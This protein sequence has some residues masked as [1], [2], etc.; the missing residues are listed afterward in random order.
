MVARGTTGSAARSGLPVLTCGSIVKNSYKLVVEEARR[1]TGNNKFRWTAA[2]ELLLKEEVSKRVILVDPALTNNSKLKE[3]A[4]DQVTNVINLNF[5]LSLSRLQVRKKFN[6]AKYTGKARVTM[7]VEKG[8]KEDGKLVAR[9]WGEFRKYGRGTGGGEPMLPPSCNDDDDEEETPKTE[10]NFFLMDTP[11]TMKVLE[12]PKALRPS[13]FVLKA[14]NAC[15]P[16]STAVSGDLKI[17]IEEKTVEQQEVDQ[18]EEEE[19]RVVPA[20]VEPERK[21]KRAS[22]VDTTPSHPNAISDQYFTARLGHINAVAPLKLQMAKEKLKYW[23]NMRKLSDHFLKDKVNILL[24][25]II[26]ITNSIKR[27]S[28]DFCS[29]FS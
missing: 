3:A 24:R 14:G 13:I 19:M 12:A 9:T 29:T 25:Y 10:N 7:A 11:S 27:D 2:Q 8:T 6:D 21:R 23:E 16:S 22:K 17:T 20:Q 4:W 28:K 15:P 5:A 18:E 1:M 26:I